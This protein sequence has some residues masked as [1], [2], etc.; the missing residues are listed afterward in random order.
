MSGIP[1][2]RVPGEALGQGVTSTLPP[3]DTK[4]SNDYMKKKNN[5]GPLGVYDQNPQKMREFKILLQFHEKKE[6]LDPKVV[7]VSQVSEEGIAC[8]IDTE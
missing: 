5:K 2:E 3:D 6:K 1:P 4:V 8:D 7:K